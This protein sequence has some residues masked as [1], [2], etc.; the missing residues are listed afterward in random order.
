MNIFLQGIISPAEPALSLKMQAWAAELQ[1][2]CHG[3]SRRGGRFNAEF[4]PVKNRG[5]RDGVTMP[6]TTGLLIVFWKC[7]APA[8]CSDFAAGLIFLFLE[9]LALRVPNHPGIDYRYLQIPKM[10]HVSGSERGMPRESDAGDLRIA[11]VH[12]MSGPLPLGSQ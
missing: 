1:A 9:P 2:A 3:N 12:R 10:P 8:G 5:I 6:R 4:L 7:V 11:H